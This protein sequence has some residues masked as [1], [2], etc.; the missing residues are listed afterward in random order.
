MENPDS[1]DVDQLFMAIFPS[2]VG[3]PE[4]KRK[5]WGETV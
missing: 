4:G 2:Y 3:L 1:E 5:K